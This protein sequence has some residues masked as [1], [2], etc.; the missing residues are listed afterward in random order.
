TSVEH[1]RVMKWCRSKTCAKL[2]TSRVA[3]GTG[4]NQQRQTTD[5]EG[6]GQR[7]RVGVTAILVAV[8]SA[9][10]DQMVACRRPRYVITGVG[11][12]G[13]HRRVRG[14]RGT[15]PIERRCNSPVAQQPNS[16]LWSLTH[17]EIGASQQ[18]ACRGEA[19]AQVVGR[20]SR[21]WDEHASV[22][23]SDV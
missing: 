7:V 22:V 2:K 16:L 12:G 8:R 20:T 11:Q 3:P 10:H 9:V 21:E 5:R 6:E 13:R 17:P 18:R 19:V 4:I 14:G 15:R 1:Q 23:V